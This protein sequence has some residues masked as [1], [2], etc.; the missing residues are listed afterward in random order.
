MSLLQYEPALS[1]GARFMSQ[2][3]NIAKNIPDAALLASNNVLDFKA[4]PGYFPSGSDPVKYAPAIAYTTSMLSWGLVQFGQGFKYSSDAAVNDA[5]EVRGM[6][7][8]CCRS[9][10]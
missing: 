2:Q 8:G 4:T 5:V 10:E 1:T 9:S 3:V 7:L 6:I